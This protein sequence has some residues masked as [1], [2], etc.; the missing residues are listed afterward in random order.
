LHL[1]DNAAFTGI[2]TADGYADPNFVGV[3]GT[4][5]DGLPCYRIALRGFFELHPPLTRE[6]L[7]ASSE[8][9][10]RLVAI[11]Q[12]Y[13]NLF[14]DPDLD[15]H[16]GGYLT[17]APP[18]L[19]GFLDQTY[20]DIAGRP[21]P[22]H[23]NHD[24][25]APAYSAEDFSTET[26]IPVEKIRLWESRLKR[27]KHVIFQGPPGTGKTFIAER[28][29]RLLISESLGFTE[30][31]QFHPSYSYEDFMQGIR[32]A[33]LGGQL[34]F[35]RAHGRFMQFCKKASKV[36]DGSPCVLII[37]EIN[38][39]NLSRIFGELMYLL[40][41]RDKAIPLAGESRP[42]R[43]PVNVHLIGTMNTADRSIALVDHALR[44][45]F[46]F[47]YLGPDYAVLRRQLERAGLPADPLVAT[48]QTMNASIEDR[49]YE[50]GISFFL[51]DGENLRLTLQDIWEGEIEPYLEEFFYDQPGK[52]D[53]FR[54]KA[55]VAGR[56]ADWNPEGSP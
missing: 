55:L 23:S 38:R 34:T 18:E 45:R 11:R 54:W 5:W 47:I 24:T 48:L 49:N 51:K 28:L 52:V 33:T 14:Y 43:I 7:A 22:L 8:R 10:E 12:K 42:F 17:E 4:T 21:L 27:K 2:S 32:P 6:E 25:R 39:G 53:P 56:L 31:L 26:A 46:S 20:R 16:Q 41:Y 19:V 44:R 50:V 35:Q 37:D 3:E 36:T 13:S 29:A 15:L 40:E 1:T 9:R 30:T